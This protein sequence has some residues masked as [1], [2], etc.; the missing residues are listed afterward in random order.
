MGF[1]KFRYV[2]FGLL[3]LET[4]LNY[5]DFQALAV[6]APTLKGP[7]GI[8][9]SD[10][11]YS[12]INMCFQ[13]AVV[14]MFLLGGWIVDFLGSRW[15]MGLAVAWWSAAEMLHGFARNPVDLMACRFLFGFAYPGAYL[16]AAKVVSEWF[17][18][19]ERALGTAV[20]TAGATVGAT[21]ASP[22]IA[23]LFGLVGWR[24]VFF[25]VGGVG[26]AFVML[27]LAIYQTP[28]RSRRVSAS[29]R[30]M[31]LRE[32][33]E[34]KA[35]N[36]QGDPTVVQV[37][38]DRRFWALAL[39]RMLGDNPWIF[40]V[41]WVPLYLSNEFHLSIREIG[42][43]GWIPFLF[44]DLGSIGGGWC[45][46]MLVR[47]G[48]PVSRARLAIMSVS[49]AVLAFTFV[50]G[51]VSS[52]AFLIGILSLMMFFTMAWMVNLSTMPVDL[53]PKQIVGR[54]TALTSTGATVGQ[55]LLTLVIGYCFV[56]HDY[57]QLFVLMSFAAPLGLL[58]IRLLIRSSAAP[59]AEGGELAAVI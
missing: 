37:L 53:F 10:G 11:D 41:S 19:N 39:G 55:T 52:A 47:R 36:G 22:L 17:P 9:M 27:W 50:M 49:A 1:P 16:A 40:Y 29:E 57:K 13:V 20:Y 59:K 54:V 5:T 44:S 56:H 18:A 2:I 51:L 38:R 30:D 4:I 25:A 12:R 26:F 23:W 58:V 34:V 48:W 31:I 21:V 42:L 24:P 6:L 28:E 45:S 8:A 3:F 43:V 35:P 32:R 7:G 46:G 14:I 15:A 33:Q